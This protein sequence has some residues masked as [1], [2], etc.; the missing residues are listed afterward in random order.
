MKQT[1]AIVCALCAAMSARGADP[2]PR[3]QTAFDSWL[4][5]SQ[6][7]ANFAEFKMSL[8]SFR[9]SEVLDPIS[10]LRTASDWERCKAVEFEVPPKASWSQLHQTLRL[11]QELK[12]RSLLPAGEPVSV[13]RHPTL[14]KCAGGA[15]N[16]AHLRASAID[17][18]PSPQVTKEQLAGL[19]RFWRSDGHKWKMGLSQYS[20]G[21]IHI[22]TAGYRTWPRKSPACAKQEQL[23]GAR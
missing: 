22:D 23:R 9:L 4:S 6:N 20:S 2:E 7:A 5:I 18:S 21:R 12:S 17:F 3:M 8:N 11:L 19:C 10:L 15:D 14:N 16:S 13:Y 1:I